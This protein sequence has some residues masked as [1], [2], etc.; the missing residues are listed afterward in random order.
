[1]TASH[2][3]VSPVASKIK[4]S[5]RFV[6]SEGMR[7]FATLILGLVL[8]AFAAAGLRGGPQGGVL[9]LPGL[10]RDVSVEAKPRESASVIFVPDRGRVAA[11]RAAV[12]DSRVV[13]ETR[14]GFATRGGRIFAADHRAANEVLARAGWADREI[15]IGTSP[16][17]AGEHDDVGAVRGKW[18]PYALWAVVALASW[19]VLRSAASLWKEVRLFLRDRRGASPAGHETVLLLR[20]NTD[21]DVAAIRAALP[22]QRILAA[23]PQ[24]L[25]LAGGW[26]RV[27]RLRSQGHVDRGGRPGGPAV[28]REPPRTSAA[29]AQSGWRGRPARMSPR[30]TTMRIG[31]IEIPLEYDQNEDRFFGVAKVPGGYMAF[32]GMSALTSGVWKRSVR[33]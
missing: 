23:T 11:V 18:F 6:D 15:R 12:D 29:I 32:H 22:P 25:V 13:A 3:L 30:P 8:A 2:W 19:I 17:P 1:L 21:D 14:G 10:A 26:I 9:D 27:R 4:I 33:R 16:P 20:V 5:H 31:G 7:T 24:G 28:R